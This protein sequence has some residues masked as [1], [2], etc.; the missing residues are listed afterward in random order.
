[1]VASTGGNATIVGG[2]VVDGPGGISSGSN[3]QVG[4]NNANI[5][6]DPRAF[7]NVQ[8]AGTAGVVQNTWRELAND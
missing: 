1:V 8:A 7:D 2:V 3:G 5:M 4:V 6:F